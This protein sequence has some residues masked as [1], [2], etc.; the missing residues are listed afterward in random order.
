MRAGFLLVWRVVSL[1]WITAQHRLKG[2][3]Q[4]CNRFSVV[5]C[6]G[7]GVS[8][9]AVAGHYSSMSWG[10]ESLSYLGCVP[11][12]QRTHRSCWSYSTQG[13][14]CWRTERLHNAW[15]RKFY[16]ENNSYFLWKLTKI[17]SDFNQKY[18]HGLLSVVAHLAGCCKL[19]MNWRKLSAAASW[20]PKR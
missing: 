5:P 7:E 4:K 2:C 6:G 1:C 11:V 19:W 10:R 14:E 13:K 3:T 20:S 15:W 18:F 12:T 17:Q 8:L 9:L 16:G